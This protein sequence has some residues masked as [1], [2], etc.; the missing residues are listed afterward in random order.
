VVTAAG[1]RQPG[2]AL[3]L[4]DVHGPHALPLRP[5]DQLTTF[6]NQFIDGGINTK[7]RA[8]F[9]VPWV[10]NKGN[11]D[12]LF[13]GSYRLYRTDNAKA[14]SAGDVAGRHQRRPHERLH[15]DRTQR[16]PRLPPQRDRRG[17]RRRGRLH[18]R[19]RRLV[20]VSPDAVTSD[21]PSWTRVGQGVLPNRP[22]SQFAVDRSDWRKAYI[23]YAG[24]S[25]ATPTA[26]G[27]VYKTVDG[28]STGPTSRTTCP[29][30]R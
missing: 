18:R 21:N 19:R 8:E 14:A 3:H 7:D 2:R 26:T 25:S 10:M 4:R 6:G 17:G 30:S 12:Q 27:H 20:Y 22:V 23:S 9:Y 1:P 16:R 28:G 5:D 29:T 11:T 13:L 24:F 15:R